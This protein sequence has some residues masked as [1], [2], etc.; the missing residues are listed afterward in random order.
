MKYLYIF[1]CLT[2][3]ACSDEP[4]VLKSSQ[5]ITGELTLEVA[6][7]NVPAD[8]YSYAE[9]SATITG[10][11]SANDRIIFTA[12]NG[13]FANG[14][15]KDTVVAASGETVKVYLKDNR[16]ER[17]KVTATA[18]G[19]A[20]EVFIDFTPAY[21][22][23]LIVNPD[24]GTL[25]SEYTSTSFIITY[26]VRNSG[27]ASQG[28]RISYRDSIATAEG[29]SIGTFTQN[30]QSDTVGNAMVRYWVQDTTYHGFVYIK[31]EIQTPTGIKKGENRIYID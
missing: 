18:F 8:D 4:E 9:V 6:V 1:L 13:A 2:L 26:L 3:I 25:P 31:G 21:P 14:M 24:I 16:V 22:D 12:E 30:T 7:G 28:Q 5:G 17:V 27:T 11:S 23:R 20:K 15:T 19:K 10:R 29:G